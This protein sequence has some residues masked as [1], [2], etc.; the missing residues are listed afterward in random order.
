MYYYFIYYVHNTPKRK[1]KGWDK[2][3]IN[4]VLKMMATYEIT[5][6]GSL[7]QYL[8]NGRELH[9]CLVKASHHKRD[10]AAGLQ[11]WG[12]ES[13][14]QFP[15]K[16]LALSTAE[17]PKVSWHPTR[18]FQC[19]T[20]WWAGL[21]WVNVQKRRHTGWLHRYGNRIIFNSPRRKNFKLESMTSFEKGIS[22]LKR[23]D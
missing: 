23:I 2:A 11:Y 13:S 22:W 16:S 4:N 19:P 1:F 8:G 21:S 3:E 10:Q 6:Y 20:I 9:L 7:S 5:G 18:L 12:R 15:A 17:I 14:A